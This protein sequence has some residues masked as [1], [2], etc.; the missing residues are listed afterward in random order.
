M[1]IEDIGMTAEET[2]LEELWETSDPSVAVD[3]LGAGTPTFVN[4]A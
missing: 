3:A 1:W 4:E 2:A